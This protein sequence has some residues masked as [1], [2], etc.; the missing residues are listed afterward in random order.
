MWVKKVT[1][2]CVIRW[3]GWVAYD[4]WRTSRTAQSH[5]N[6]NISKSYFRITILTVCAL[7]MISIWHIF[8]CSNSCSKQ[9]KGTDIMDFFS[10]QN[11][12]FFLILTMLE[13]VIISTRSLW[14]LYHASCS[15]EISLCPPEKY[16]FWCGWWVGLGILSSVGLGTGLH[17]FL[18]YLGNELTCLYFQAQSYLYRLLFLSVRPAKY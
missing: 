11:M 7:R 13:V 12:F 5:R 9:K 6:N 17:T 10:P 4:A 1:F 3:I 2:F 8:F 14:S 15:V 16:V 18:L